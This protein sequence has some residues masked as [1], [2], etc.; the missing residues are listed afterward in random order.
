MG[1]DFSETDN[2]VNTSIAAGANCAFQ[3]TFAPSATGS[4]TGQLTITA[5]ITGGQLTVALS[6]TGAS[7]GVVSLTPSTIGFGQVEV[8]TTS[9]PLPVQAANSGGTA[10]AI[11]NI[12]ITAPFTLASNSCGTTS[13]SADT[14]CQIQVAFAPTQAGPAMGT[15]T[16]VDGIGT[17]IVALSGTGAAVPTD[18]L[19][20]AFLSPFR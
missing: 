2:C 6:G 10:V 8:G 14:S 7:A 9:A 19:N 12:S 18:S 1:G 17:Q 13:L 11:T 16:L 15:L 4:R 5:N 3:V 20:P